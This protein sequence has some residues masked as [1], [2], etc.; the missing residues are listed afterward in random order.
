MGIIGVFSGLALRHV[1]C[2]FAPKSR[3]HIQ[4]EVWG[5]QNFGITF[6]RGE[7]VV[8]FALALSI[9]LLCVVKLFRV[10]E[11]DILATEGNQLNFNTVREASCSSKDDQKRIW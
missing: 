7:P 5:V 9:Y 4:R 3:L 11:R 1:E 10:L 8:V 6:E 2:S